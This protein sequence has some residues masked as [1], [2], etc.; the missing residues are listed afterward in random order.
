[1][2]TQSP[3]S[4]LPFRHAEAPATDRDCPI[5]SPTKKLP[6]FQLEL[7]D[8]TV[9]GGI[10]VALI[11]YQT[12]TVNQVLSGIEVFSAD[13]GKTYITYTGADL[14]PDTAPGLYRIRVSGDDIIAPFFSHVLCLTPVF[15]P[16]DW[17]PSIACDEGGDGL[18]FTVSYNN[19]PGLP[20]EIEVNYGS[21]AGWQ[22]IGDGLNEPPAKFFA[23]DAPLNAVGLRLKVWLEDAIFYK[24]YKF[25]FD[26]DNPSP[27]DTGV[28]AFVNYGGQGY[29]RFLC[30]EWQNTRDLQ[31]LGLLY[32]GVEGYDG[33][34]Q[35]LYIEG[36]ASMAGTVAE[37]NFLRNGQGRNILDSMEIARLYNVQFYGLP[38]GC[39]APLRA[40]NAHNVRRLRRVVDGWVAELTAINVT[41]EEVQGAP[42]AK[43]TLSLETNRALIGC[44]DN[45]TE[46]I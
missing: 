24:E 4:T 28:L 10:E 9:S 14:E 23:V 1:M 41:T 40:A 20:T 11:D 27:C 8:P 43:C 39:I 18:E 31:A 16:Q 5:Y 32:A 44:Q 34:L 22:R 25:T 45:L 35:Q 7:N 29:E 13:N 6:M 3:Y 17:E 33:F 36:W 26:P 46:V 19:H 15:N 2:I 42:C 12:G 37:E 38:D 21:G 30:V